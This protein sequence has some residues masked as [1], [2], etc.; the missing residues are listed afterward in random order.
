[1]AEPI[2]MPFGLCMTK[3]RKR[4]CSKSWDPFLPTWC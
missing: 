3:Y 4:E 1:M 2:M